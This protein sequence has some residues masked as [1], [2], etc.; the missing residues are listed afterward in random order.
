MTLNNQE[1]LVLTLPDYENKQKARK[2]VGEMPEKMHVLEIKVFRDKRSGEANSKAWVLIGKIAQ[3]LGLNPL[4]VYRRHVEE[5][6]K[7]DQYLMIEAAYE[8]FNR[9]WM[10]DHIGRYSKIIGESR[11]KPGYVWVAAF[12]GSS[13][14]DT[15]TMYHFLENI[16]YECSALGIETLSPDEMERIMSRWEAHEQ[17][18]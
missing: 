12:Y 16:M 1:H 13:N 17:K 9:A 10:Y 18:H 4:D 11:E 6:G 14:Y 15:K 5:I 3:S 8:E 7:F 2:F